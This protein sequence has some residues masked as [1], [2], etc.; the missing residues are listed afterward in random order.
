MIK[1]IKEV[2]VVEGNLYEVWGEDSK[3]VVFDVL[4]E[5]ILLNGDI[6]YHN[7][8]FKG[9]VRDE[10]GFEHPNYYA[11]VDA[12]NLADRVKKAGKINLDHWYHYGN[13]KVLKTRD[14]RLAEAWS[15][16]SDHYTN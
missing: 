7:H 6:Y 10:E 5:A 8:C 14:E 15:D 9:H 3:L 1:T 13:V 2:N 4:V 11:V 16:T 12:K